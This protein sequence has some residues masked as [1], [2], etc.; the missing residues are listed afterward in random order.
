MEE[1]MQKRRWRCKH[2]RSVKQWGEEEEWI[3]EHK[4]EK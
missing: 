3:K 4:K 2:L 1:K